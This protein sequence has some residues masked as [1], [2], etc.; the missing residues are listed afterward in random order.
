[1]STPCVVTGNLEQLTGGAITKGSVRFK[2]INFGVGNPVGVMGITVFPWNVYIVVSDVTGFFT[3]NLWGNDVIN[4]ANTLY[5]VTYYDEKGDSL[6]DV[7]YSIVGPSFN[8]NTATPVAGAIPPVLTSGGYAS[9]AAVTAA[10]FTFAGWGTGATL[11]NVIGV[12]ERCSVTITAGVSP[13]VAPTV[14]FTFP[15]A[16][17]TQSLTIAQMTNGSGSISDIKDTST[18][19]QAVYTYVGLPAAT[20][21]YVLVFDTTGT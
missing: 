2:L 13:V 10:N 5:L 8:M 19:T 15:G 11:T 14:T 1:M 17:P 21:T 7:Q 18:T 9:G 12:Q 20:K 4:P 16:Y 3:V 6:G